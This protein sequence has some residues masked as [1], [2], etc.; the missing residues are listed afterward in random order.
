M[1]DHIFLPL[2]EVSVDPTT[3]PMLHRFLNMVV[4]FDCVDDESKHESTRD[5]ADT[6][7]PPSE[8]TFNR[9]PPYFYWVY[10]LSANLQSLNQLRASRGLTTFSF[11]PHAG[12]AGDLSHVRMFVPS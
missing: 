1:L 7:P 10:Y 4:G 2:F 3:N 11:R 8:W 6:M 5:A 9:S 12:E